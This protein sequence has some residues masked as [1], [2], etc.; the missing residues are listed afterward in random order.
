M[1]KLPLHERRPVRGIISSSST[2]QSRP[3]R[4]S[5]IFRPSSY[6]IAGLIHN[7]AVELAQP[8]RCSKKSNHPLCLIPIPNSRNH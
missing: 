2:P 1:P 5:T 8:P 7:Y 6:P 3:N 4:V